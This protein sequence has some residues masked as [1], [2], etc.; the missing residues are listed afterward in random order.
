MRLFS[1]P[2]PPQSARIN[3]ADRRAKRTAEGNPMNRE[4]PKAALERDRA[5]LDARYGAIGIS[6]V[7]AAVR[8]KSEARNPAYAPVTPDPDAQAELLER[9]TS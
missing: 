5:D 7:A 3:A 9:Q 1:R 4:H 2:F 8:Y 6:A